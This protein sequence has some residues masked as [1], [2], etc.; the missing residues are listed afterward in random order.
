MILL[1]LIFEAKVSIPYR[2]QQYL[3]RCGNQMTGF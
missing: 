2:T 3:I 1:I